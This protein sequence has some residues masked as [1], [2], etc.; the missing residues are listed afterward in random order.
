M[1]KWIRKGD[2]VKVITGNDKGK[3]GGVLKRLENKVVV[4]GVNV[5]K[6]HL[7]KT[8][9]NPA[10]RIIE[11]GTPIHTSNVALCDAEGKILKVRV[12]VGDKTRE[13][14]LVYKMG[15]KNV[16]YRTVKKPA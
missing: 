13:R 5:R 10:G 4:E 8:Q 3:V 12:R 6:K 14:E 9:E 15:S 11:M 7:K 16:L 2:L 1:S